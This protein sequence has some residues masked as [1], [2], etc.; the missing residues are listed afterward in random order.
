M[1]G[2]TKVQS[3]LWQHWEKRGS[4]YIV[5]RAAVKALGMAQ[6]PKGL[7]RGGQKQGTDLESSLH[8]S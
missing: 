7:L 8:R 6:T 1:A 3:Q 2:H 5:L 4:S